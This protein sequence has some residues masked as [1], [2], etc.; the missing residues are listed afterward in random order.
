MSTNLTPAPQPHSRSALPNE[1]AAR[2]A[3][4]L[5]VVM[6]EARPWLDPD[7]NLNRL[8]SA[9]ETSPHHLSELL[10]GRMATTFHELVTKSR[11]AES[12]RRLVDPANDVF[13]IEA[14]AEA[15]GFSSRSGFYAAFRREYGV[16]PTQFRKQARRENV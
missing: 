8:A 6:T 3:A 10:N 12:K 4:R 13:T 7:L 5:A 16:T 11:L 15:S 1:T 14:I 9:V 2:L